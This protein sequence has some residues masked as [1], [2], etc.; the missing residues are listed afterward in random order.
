MT[1]TPSVG[2]VPW[3]RL[4]V[5]RL[6]AEVER[7]L[8]TLC[9]V[10]CAAASALLALR[11]T[12]GAASAGEMEDALQRAFPAQAAEV[13]GGAGFVRKAGAYAARVEVPGGAGPLE[14]AEAALAARGG[15]RLSLPSSMEQGAATLSLP[16]LRLRVT[17]VGAHEQARAVRAA[18]AY[19]RQGG[20]SYWRTTARGYE[21]WVLVAEAHAG[22]LLEW[23][24]DGGTLAEDGDE[25][26][27]LD[28]AGRARVRV[29]APTA[30]AAGGARM[31][32]WLRVEGGTRIVLFTDARGPSLIDPAWTAVGEMSTVRQGHTALLLASGQV[33]VAGGADDTGTTINTAEL[34]DPATTVWTLTGSL[35]ESRTAHT[36]TLLQD[37]TVLVV[38]G[39]NATNTVNTALAS[40]ELY[41]PAPGSWTS[42]GALGTRR[43]G[44]TATLLSSGVVLVAGGSDNATVQTPLAS[45]E[46]YDPATGKWTA[47]A[48]MADARESHTATLLA[49][50]MV[51]VAGGQGTS[52][53]L[54]SAELYD[55]V[56]ATWNPAG[57]MGAHREFQTAT[58]LSSG[59]VLVAAGFDGVT[60]LTSAEL[61]DPAGGW[62]GTG[63]LTPGRDSH[64]ATLLSSG[65]VLV[66][67]GYNAGQSLA[68]AV[69]YDPILG[70]WAA[71]G[72]LVTGRELH[73][74]TT[75]LPSGKVLA[76]GGLGSNQTYLASAETYQSLGVIP[77]TLSLAP[78]ARQ[79]FQAIGGSLTGYTWAFVTNASGGSLSPSGAYTAGGVGSVTDVIG[80][81]DSLGNSATATVTVTEGVAIS[82]SVAT[83][84]P[85]EAKAFTATGGSGTY[86][87][88]F[89]TNASGA[90]LSRGGIYTAGETSGVSD[91]IK[92]TDSLGNSATA[93]VNVRGESSGCGCTTAA[94]LWPALALA[95][96]PLLRARR[97]R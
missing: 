61:Y 62:V 57:A 59:K 92:A 13:L 74:A 9:L 5:R 94:D 79:G 97:R 81:T 43:L 84:T 83:V 73:T 39:Q 77:E 20:V 56:G 55:P 52:S 71:T 72:P 69:L 14:A 27:V 70:T 25:V 96:M 63:S 8:C 35:A 78:R 7:F 41:D 21:E 16:G 89:V 6:G 32:A 23:N 60:S 91:E 30:F 87:W 36:M 33:L 15:L 17:E 42:T 10:T 31:R 75:L 26:L 51:L 19:P 48:S 29:T 76:A 37:G 3:G 53:V 46:L 90:T 11:G 24:V 28:G 86:T 22:P 66:A 68:S 18:V 49:S 34:Y 67:G 80:L 4:P 88:A 45:A 47:A 2:A 12:S 64:T 40:A 54:N 50:G 85:K 95:A 82:P 38:G 65:Q 58:L 44:H 1:A 93:T